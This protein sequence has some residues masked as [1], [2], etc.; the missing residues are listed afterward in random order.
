MPHASNHRLSLPAWFAQAVRHGGRCCRALIVGVTLV[1]PA[2]AAETGSRAAVDGLKLAVLDLPEN[3]YLAGSLSESPALAAG[4][5]RTILWQSPAFA[6]PFEF[7]LDSVLGIRFPRPADDALPQAAG[8]WRIE[9]F[10]GDRLVGGLESIDDQQVVVTIGPAA[11][12]ARSILR[13]D[14]VRGISR[15]PGGMGITAPGGLVDWQE[16]PPDGWR[17]EAGRIVSGTA[18]TGLFRDL[19]SGPRVRYDIALSWPQRPTLQIGLACDGAKD[20]ALPYCLEL[21]PEGMVAVREEQ[22]AGDGRTDLEPFGDL[23]ETGLKLVVFVDQVAGRMVVMLPEAAGGAFKPVVD[24]TVPPA[25]GSRAGGFQLAVVGAISFDEFRVAA[26]RGDAPLLTEVDE[27]QVRLR[28]GQ[29]LKAVVKGMQRSSQVFDIRG[30]TEPRGIP[31]DQVE[32]IVFPTEVQPPAAAGASLFASSAV[33]ATDILG[34]QLTGTLQRVEQGVAWLEHRAIEGPVPL[35]ISTLAT[36]VSTSRPL[37]DQELP[38]RIGRMMCEQGAVRGCLVRGERAGAD[39]AGDHAVAPAAAIAWQPMGSLT[40]SPLAVAADG[41][42]PPA[43]IK[44]MYAAIPASSDASVSADAVGGLG[45]HIGMSQGRPVITGIKVLQ[46]PVGGGPNAAEAVRPGDVIL[47]IA[48]RGDGQFLDTQGLS[49]EDAQNLLRG[50]V[51]SQLQI[52]F[53][54]QDGEQ[55]PREVEIVRQQIFTG[56]GLLQQALQTHDRLVPQKVKPV[57]SAAPD[58]FGSRLILRTGE[59]L[60]CRIAAIDEDGLR[61]QMAGSELVTVS[62][63]MVQAVEL[64]PAASRPLPAEKF[65]SLV[66]LPR[67]QQQ[68]PPTHVLRS[69]QGDYLR[70]RLV[71]L[72]EQTIRIALEASSQDTP[73][74]IPR[75]NVARLMWLHPEN[76]DTPWQ[77]PQTAP[78]QGLLVEGIGSENDR[79]RMVVTD[80]DGNLLIGK[81]P[82]FGPC[83][84]DLGAVNQLLIGRTSDD[85]ARPVPYSQWGLRLAPEPRNLPP[86]Q[87]K[88]TAQE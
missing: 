81:S 13:R 30:D 52:Q 72:D 22:A 28:D 26:W 36:L 76:L 75:G 32:E 4:P 63:E 24:L 59:T 23:P 46:R 86:R 61:L 11:A 45:G 57:D 78:G 54:A 70:G 71:S 68:Q 29:V 83:R 31:V 65:R 50:R 1:M 16:Q 49:L 34:T 42:Q 20:A 43:E 40:A 2:G 66:T 62:S 60:A 74:A 27:G 80:I 17:E 73:L 12:T 67:S 19:K 82:V 85:R 39:D 79:L 6:A 55:K 7:P 5:R 10:N 8:D 15:G 18:R 9:L 88:S 41:G 56:Q 21:S 25:A 14:A 87:A 58:W 38:G 64:V 84:L 51:G 48:P 3:G 53:Q 35:P 44:V 69:V 37:A 33:R 47:A 77:A